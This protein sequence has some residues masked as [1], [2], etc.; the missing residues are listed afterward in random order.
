MMRW[1]FSLPVAIA[2]VLAL[3]AWAVL[4]AS[5]P[6]AS[7]SVAFASEPISLPIV[8]PAWPLCEGGNRAERRVTCVV[9]GDTFWLFGEKHRLACIDTPELNAEDPQTR[10]RAQLATR[11]LQ[12]LLADPSARLVLTGREDFFGRSLSS[13]S[14]IGADGTARPAEADM[15]LFGLAEWT[16]HRNTRAHCAGRRGPL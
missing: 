10:Y 8:G 5:P 9:D 16:D 15:V 14:L 13:I 3:L 11:H 7:A 1:L 12:R 4:R 6:P 2:V